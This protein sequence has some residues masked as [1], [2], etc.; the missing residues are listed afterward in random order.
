M[1]IDE[2]VKRFPHFKYDFKPVELAESL[3]QKWPDTIDD[4][5]ATKDWDWQPAFDFE[6]SE[7]AETK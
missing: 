4:Q 7:S 5:V 2:I 6:K 3:I 1:V